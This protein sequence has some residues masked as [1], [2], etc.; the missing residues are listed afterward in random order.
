MNLD[1]E[2]RIKAHPISSNGPNSGAIIYHRSPHPEFWQ[3]L[4]IAPYVA[5]SNGDGRVVPVRRV[6]FPERLDRA[7]RRHRS[8]LPDLVL[9]GGLGDPYPPRE[10]RLRR[11]RRTI[12]VLAKHSCPFLLVTGS[13]LVLRDIDLIR[14]VHNDT[15]ATVALA[16]PT[17]SPRAGRGL[18]PNQQ[19]VAERLRVLERIRRSG[20]QTGV[21]VGPF[22]PDYYRRSRHL[23]PFFAV[24]ANLKLDFVVVPFAVDHFY[25]AW[26][27]GALQDS[28]RI[29]QRSPKSAPPL[30]PPPSGGGK[31]PLPLHSRGRVRGGKVILK[32]AREFG[33]CLRPKRFLPLDYR[34]ENY[35]LAGELADRAYYLSLEGRSPA[36]H[37]VA[38][39]RI[40]E[41]REDLRSI[42]RRG[43][44]G[45]MAFP[46]E[47][48]RDEVERLLRGERDASR[49]PCP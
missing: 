36:A 42:V 3:R 12:E 25:R 44:V 22:V 24:A 18:E 16:M 27:N 10:R 31:S 6:G 14:E 11:T 23:A 9:I 35:W 38:A 28:A 4:T 7:L 49:R 46:N 39:R 21:V 20:V 33:V 5:G 37:L 15:G 30:L 41:L 13:T 34:H 48:V 26:G 43:G 8:R 1:A 2:D 19:P 45:E 17:L 32:L 29:A 40:N 47:S